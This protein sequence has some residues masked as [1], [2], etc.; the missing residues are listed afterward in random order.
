M[1]IKQVILLMLMYPICVFSQNVGQKGDSIINY[2]DIN[3]MKQGH[4]QK[5]YK[6]EQ[7]AY[8][9]YFVNDKPVGEYKRYYANGK[10]SAHIIYDKEGNN[11]KAK[12]Y[13]DDGKLMAEGNYINAN[14]K[15]SVWKFYGADE[16]V[17]AE[18]TYKSGIKD[19]PATNYYKNGNK[20]ELINFK[21]DIKEGLWRQYFDDG[22][23]RFETVFKDGKR[24][25]TF[26]YYYQS[27]RIKYKGKYV[28]DLKH[29]KFIEYETD[30]SVKTEIEYVYGK[31]TNEDELNREFAKEIE[32]A[33]KHKDKYKEPTIEDVFKN[34]R[35]PQY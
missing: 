19:G 15:D 17:V 25:G 9:A 1:K 13:W 29:G 23:T 2:V 32:E 5:K 11:G 3:G 20:S 14:V 27:G 22:S 12:I 18:V 7:I 28:N 10:M 4:W 24:N 21:N 35:N 30:G 8:D 31:A 33:D 26:H 34:N 16:R 6:N